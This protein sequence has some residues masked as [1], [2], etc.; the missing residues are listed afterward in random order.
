MEGQSSSFIQ[1]GSCQEQSLHTAPLI[2]HT[3]EQSLPMAA[4]QAEQ[5]SLLDNR[6]RA[7][8]AESQTEDTSTRE[9]PDA[10]TWDWSK[11]GDEVVDYDEQIYWQPDDSDL[12]D[13]DKRKI[14]ATTAKIVQDAFCLPWN[15][16]KGRASR[17]NNPLLIPPSPRFPGWTPPSSP[18]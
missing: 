5:Q 9:R 14:S 4:T 18:G 17:E 6:D 13:S 8:G 10:T 1:T 3:E 15:P 16:E 2:V 7:D 12:A 11:D